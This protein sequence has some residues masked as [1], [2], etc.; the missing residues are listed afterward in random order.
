MVGFQK[1]G[2]LKSS[3]SQ[4][5][6]QLPVQVAEQDG[7]NLQAQNMEQFSCGHQEQLLNHHIRPS[8][9][10]AQCKHP[11]RQPATTFAAK[12][13]DLSNGKGRKIARTLM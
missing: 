11:S 2:F 8:S 12:T 1:E 5:R 4:G 9:V 7:A 13:E 6:D 3:T 10:P